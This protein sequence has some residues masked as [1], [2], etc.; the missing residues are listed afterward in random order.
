[1]ARRFLDDRGVALTEF[2]MTL[3]FLLALYSGTYQLCDAYSVYRK[4]TITSRSLADLT[5]QCVTVTTS[6]LGKILAASQQVMSPY[7]SN[8]AQLTIS[9]VKIDNKGNATVDWSAAQNTTALK[10]GAPFNVPTNIKQNN[11]WIVVASVAYNY[12]PLFAGKMFGPINMT[13]TIVMSPRRSAQVS[14]STTLSCMQ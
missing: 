6:D 3:P 5:T 8:N 9:Q 12:V 7:N 14:Q 1:M 13:N 10:P 11:T 4:V 2:A